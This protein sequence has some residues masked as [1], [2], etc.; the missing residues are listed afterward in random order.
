M[1][2]KRRFQAWCGLALLVALTFI[3]LATVGAAQAHSWY[4]ADCCSAADCEMVKGSPDSVVFYGDNGG[5]WRLP[6]GQT[7]P[8][9]QTRQSIDNEFHWCRYATGKIIEANQTKCLYVPGGGV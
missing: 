6:D 7:V 1:S 3:G 8:A 9:S 2:D 4:D 5:Y